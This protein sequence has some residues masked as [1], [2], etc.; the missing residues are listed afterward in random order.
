[1]ATPREQLANALKQ[2]RVDAGY[3][4]HLALAKRLTVSRPVITRAENAREAVPSPALIKAWAEATGADLAQLNDFAKRARSP[5][6]EFAKWADDFEQ[7]ATLLREFAPLLVPGLLQTEPYAR[8]LVN[9]KPER[10]DAET[11]LKSRLARQ[12][13]LDRAELRVLILGS[14]L[15]RE[16]GSPSVM[17]EQIEHLLSVGDRPSVMMQVVPDV[18]EVAGGLGGSFA[19]STEGGHDTAAY[20]DATVKGSVF[21]DPDLVARTVR[22]FDALRADALPWRQTT[23]FLRKAGTHYESKGSDVAESE[24]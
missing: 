4:S 11:N 2:A 14:V 23:D 18:P 16:V 22:A 19:I 20:T 15:Y 17:C 21:T 24:G 8:A 1:M 3:G 5:Q 9:W 7:R 13:V 12:S 10:G 6:S